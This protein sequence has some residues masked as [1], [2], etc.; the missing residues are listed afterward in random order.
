MRVAKGMLPL[1]LCAAC[2][3]GGGTF[4]FDDLRY[5][6][7][8]SGRV[9]GADGVLVDPLDLRVVGRLEVHERFWGIVYGWVDVTGDVDVGQRINEEIRKSGG[10]AVVNMK[11]TAAHCALNLAPIVSLLPVWPGCVN[12]EIRGQIVKYM[13][14]A[15]A[16]EP[17]GDRVAVVAPREAGVLA[18]RLLAEEVN[19][20]AARTGPAARRNVP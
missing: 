13:P 10:E 5:P 3:S 7:S 16:G 14:R 1:L 8:M 11:A 19:A 20:L 17:Q 2:A 9:H 6:V 15:G 18:E 4:V 12:G